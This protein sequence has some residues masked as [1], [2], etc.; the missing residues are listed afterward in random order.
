[1][2]EMIVFFVILF[3]LPVTLIAREGDDMQTAEEIIR[4][5]DLKPLP[6]EGG[7]YRETYRSDYGTNPAN[8]FDVDADSDRNL[9]TAIYYLVS[10]GSFSAIHRIKS[11]EV[12]HFYAG[13][14]IEM[15]QI[16]AEGNKSNIIMGNNVLEGQ[17]PQVVVP[18]NGWQALRLV[19]GGSW[20]LWGTTVAPGFEFEDFE[21]GTRKQMLQLFPQHEDDI[22]RFTRESHE[23]AH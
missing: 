17:V 21:V 16:D 22:I 20:A 11:D 7:Y 6:E 4:V 18:R 1:M 19:E 13:D 5:M 23:K 8:V 15:M 9:S 12:F 10:A 2:K 3:S 14:P